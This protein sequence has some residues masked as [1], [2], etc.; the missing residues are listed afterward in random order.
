M[1]NTVIFIFII[2]VPLALNIIFV[3]W[4][5]RSS[6]K[7]KTLVFISIVYVALNIVAPVVIGE[8]FLLEPGQNWHEEFVALVILILLARA[9]DLW[10][11]GLWRLAKELWSIR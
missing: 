9:I 11:F 8:H 10:P 3:Y 4:W 7:R 2:T 5:S 6:H 1:M